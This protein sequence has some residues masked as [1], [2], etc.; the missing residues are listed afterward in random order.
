MCPGC[1]AAGRRRARSAAS[2]GP[3][4]PADAGPQS[5]LHCVASS[6]EKPFKPHKGHKDSLTR[7]GSG[8]GE[9]VTRRTR[10]LPGTDR[11]AARD[12]YPQP[13]S[14][15]GHEASTKPP[16]GRPRRD[17]ALT[18]RKT[19]LQGVSQAFLERL[20]GPGRP[21]PRLTSRSSAGNRLRTC[22]WPGYP[23]HLLKPIL[24]ALDR[25]VAEAGCRGGNRGVLMFSPD[26]HIILEFLLEAHP[27]V[28]DGS[29]ERSR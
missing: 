22:H 13:L 16:G 26:R 4:Q 23:L 28:S 18:V 19:P 17:P 11:R 3:I 6:S 9:G 5:A 25:D 8:F 24:I 15:A 7:T 20:W 14:P 21:R 2:Q 12:R 27:C 29:Q 10:R 1:V